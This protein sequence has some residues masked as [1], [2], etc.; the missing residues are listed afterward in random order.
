[1]IVDTHIVS[2]HQETPIDRTFQLAIPSEDREAFHFT[3]GQFVVVHDPREA[4]PRR[5]AYSISSPPSTAPF[6]ELTVRDMGTFG[7]TFYGLPAGTA[8]AMRAPAG[9]FVLQEAPGERVLMVAGGSGVTP[10]RAF[11]GDMQARRAT[12]PATLL[13]TA[14]QP[15]ELVFHERFSGWAHAHAPFTYVPTV[16]RAAPEHPWAG[17]RGRIDAALLHAHLGA[18][19]RT[20]FYACGPAP[21]VQAMLALA[22]EAGIPADRRHKEQ[23]G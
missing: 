22:E 16:T 6:L 21:F 14:Q 2:V 17:R 19:E 20:R 4:K 10:F 13:Q 15:E 9:R 3:P 5:R 18:P 8:L 23:W 12:T 1:M 7:H 11:V